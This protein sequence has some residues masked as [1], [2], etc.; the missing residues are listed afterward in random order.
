[1]EE[2]QLILHGK[3]LEYNAT[4]FVRYIFGPRNRNPRLAKPERHGKNLSE[5][6]PRLCFI[7]IFQHPHL[8]HDKK[9]QPRPLG[10]GVEKLIKFPRW[11]GKSLFV[12]VQRNMIIPYVNQPASVEL[13]DAPVKGNLGLQI[14]EILESGFMPD[15]RLREIWSRKHRRFF[16]KI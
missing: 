10:Y 6:H 8:R 3:N 13:V 2:K 7:A 15:P 14:F 4:L 9:I 11:E 12:Q 16:L 1:M 5:V